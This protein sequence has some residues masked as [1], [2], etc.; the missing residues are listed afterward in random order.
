MANEFLAAIKPLV[1]NRDEIVKMLIRQMRFCGSSD[2]PNRESDL[3]YLE[4]M[5]AIFL[6]KDAGEIFKVPDTG[7]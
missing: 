6:A 7:E 2:D 3:V 4:A 1:N 5:L